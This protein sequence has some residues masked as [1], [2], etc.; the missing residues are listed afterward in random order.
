MTDEPP[1]KSLAERQRV[2]DQIWTQLPERQNRTSSSW[3]FLILFPEGETGFGPEQL[4]FVI[5]ARVGDRLS[6]NGVPVPGMNLSRTLQNGVDRFPAVSIG[7]HGNGQRV[8]QHIINQPAETTLSSEGSIRAWADRGA[9]PRRGGEIRASADRPFGLDVHFAGEGGEARFE[10]WVDSASGHASPVVAM[11]IDTAAGGAH[12]VALRRMRFEGSFELPEVGQ[13]QLEGLCYFHRACLN[14]PLFPWKWVWAFFPDG[15]AFSAFVPFIGPQLFRKGY[16][17]FSSNTLERAII[18]IRRS[19]L[20]D[21]NTDEQPVSF[22]SA[23]VKPVFGSNPHPRF[24]VYASNEEGDFVEFV[25]SPYGHIR[26]YIDRPLLGGLLESHWSYNEYLFRIEDL[27]GRIGDR[28]ISNGTMGQ[29]FGTLE[30]A[31]GLG[32]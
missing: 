29:G 32:L 8:P 4:M 23:H 1:A 22:S 5:A 28:I 6:V 2:F 13:K 31:W 24:D 20:W 21:P 11:D 27:Q 18:P 10:A 19:G 7:W 26:S 3:W 30:Y 12:L 15:T 25:A 17:F 9:S 16:R 14:V